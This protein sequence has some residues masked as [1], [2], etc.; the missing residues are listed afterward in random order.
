MFTRTS[1]IVD[2][3]IQ[4]YENRLGVTLDTQIP[5]QPKPEAQVSPQQSPTQSHAFHFKLV[6]IIQK[7][8]KPQ[9][10][11]KNHLTK[12]N[13]KSTCQKRPTIYFHKSTSEWATSSNA[14]NTLQVTR[15]TVKKSTWG[16]KRERNRK[17]SSKIH[18]DQ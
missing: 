14:G 6:Q 11:S 2:Q 5:L 7:S 18:P 10:Q 3:L 4:K 1:A 17:R 9:I 15:F 12:K 16:R 13:Q 8:Q